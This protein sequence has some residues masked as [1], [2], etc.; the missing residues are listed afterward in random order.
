[1][2][3]N[4]DLLVLSGTDVDKVITKFTPS[5]LVNLMARVFTTLATAQDDETQI[6]VPHRSTVVTTNHRVLFMPSR[7][8]SLGTSVKIVS[9]PTAN[10]P[11]DV[12]AR[13][14]PGSTAVIDERSGEVVALVNAR[15]LTALRNA[16]SKWDP[17]VYPCSTAH[18]YIY[19]DGNA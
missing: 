16:A 8:A 4:R 10:A 2:P 5:D 7:L 3:E 9:V 13:G 1:M 6:S 18:W 12:K 14:L 15:K 11:E 17:S 19:S